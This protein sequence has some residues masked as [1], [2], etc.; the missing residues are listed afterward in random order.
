LLNHSKKYAVENVETPHQR[1]ENLTGLMLSSWSQERFGESDGL[2]DRCLP[3]GIRANDYVYART[4]MT[5]Y[6]FKRSEVLYCN[7]ADMHA[8]PRSFIVPLY[9]IAT[10]SC[11]VFEIFGPFF[12]DG[13]ED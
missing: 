10:I 9:R 4:Q 2:E 6:V 7:M 8:Y 12:I 11:M 3:N 5:I 1:N 13:R